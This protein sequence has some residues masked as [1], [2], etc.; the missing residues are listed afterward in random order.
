MFCLRYSFLILRTL[1]LVAMFLLGSLIYALIVIL[2][3][4]IIGF[5]WMGPV[6]AGYMVM[7]FSTFMLQ[8][9]QWIGRECVAIGHGP[10][11]AD[12]RYNIF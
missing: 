3:I 8:G 1:R 6:F 4:M 7:K 5:M 9:G 12:T 2:L 10:V 11:N